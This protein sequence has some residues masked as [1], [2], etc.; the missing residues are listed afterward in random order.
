MKKLLS[1]LLL[2]FLLMCMFSCQ[3]KTGDLD[4]TTTGSDTNTTTD[5]DTDTENTEPDFTETEPESKQDLSDITINSSLSDIMKVIYNGVDTPAVFESEITADNVAYFLGLEDTTMYSEA[6]SSDAM[7]S[8][9]PHSVCL[10]RIAEGQDVDEIKSLI[11]ENANPN[12]WICVFA[13]RVIVDNIDNVVVLIMDGE[14]TANEL[15]KN[16]L[17]LK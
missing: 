13:E 10:V 8:A 4:E 12:K 3:E 15:H 6:L 1:I 2:S 7:I 16:F 11:E 14:K 9:I 5:K 17:T